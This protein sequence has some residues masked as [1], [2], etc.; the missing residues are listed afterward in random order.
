MDIASTFNKPLF[1]KGRM[2]NTKIHRTALPSL[3][4]KKYVNDIS[5]CT[6]LS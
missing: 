6:A 1:A 3:Q 4:M 5:N 2:G